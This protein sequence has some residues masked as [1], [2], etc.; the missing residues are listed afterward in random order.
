MEEEV[1]S[2][3]NRDIGD[4]E[5]RDKSLTWTESNPDCKYK[6]VTSFYLSTELKMC[7]RSKMKNVL[8]NIRRFRSALVMFAP[9]SLE[10]Q[11]SELPQQEPEVGQ[12]QEG[13]LGEGTLAKSLTWLHP[14]T[15]VPPSRSRHTLSLCIGFYRRI[16]VGRILK[17][18]KAGRQG[19]RKRKE[20]L[21]YMS[22]KVILYGLHPHL[23]LPLRAVC[24]LCS[25]S[26]SLFSLLTFGTR[27]IILYQI[28]C[29]KMG[30]TSLVHRSSGYF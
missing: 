13:S 24:V 29:F 22:S 6:L 28:I 8:F 4:L 1:R 20:S 10:A 16:I 27:I 25:E 5:Y 11:T 19:E 15:T 30:P 3:R 2:H 14:Q 12:V 7:H 17:S 9:C 26:L 23:F 21:S 18:R